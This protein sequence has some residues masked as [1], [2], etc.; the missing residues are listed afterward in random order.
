MFHFI[1]NV[2]DQNVSKAHIDFK[3]EKWVTSRE[4]GNREGGPH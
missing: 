1:R 2:F 4:L 3:S